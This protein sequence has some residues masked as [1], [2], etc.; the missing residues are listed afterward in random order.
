MHETVQ[1]H[2]TAASVK[3]MRLLFTPPRRAP[4]VRADR[5]AACQ[6]LD[7]LVSNAIKFSAPGRN[8]TLRLEDGPGQWV[9]LVVEDEGPG[10][11]EEDKTKMFRR[12]GRLTAR[13]TGGEPTTGLGLSIVKRLVATMNG[14][15]AV[16]SQP[17]Q[18]AGFFVRLPAIR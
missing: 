5:E 13:P 18:G 4:E 14:R 17:G 16:E 11:S 7:N 8:V 1:R 6:V 9:T 15:I 10:F 2:Q 3:Q 12:Y